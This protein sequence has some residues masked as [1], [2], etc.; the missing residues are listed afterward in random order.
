MGSATSTKREG[1]QAAL[2]H[3]LNVQSRSTKTFWEHEATA[4]NQWVGNSV[5]LYPSFLDEVTA[6]CDAKVCDAVH[7]ARELLLTLNDEPADVVAL[8][9]TTQVW[10]DDCITMSDEELAHMLECDLQCA[11][12]S[13]QHKIPAAKMSKA[14]RSTAGPFMAYTVPCCVEPSTASLMLVAPAAPMPTLRVP[15]LTLTRAQRVARYKVKR[16]QRAE[17]KRQV[18]CEERSDRARKRRRVGGRFVPSTTTW[19]SAG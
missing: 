16:A 4:K 13:T 2:A 11:A 15:D 10:E 3:A 5:T 6:H 7:C 9:E 17:P 12:S 8:P 1:H 18:R 14:V 19:V